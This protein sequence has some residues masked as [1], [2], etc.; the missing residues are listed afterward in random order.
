MDREDTVD[1]APSRPELSRLDFLR[2]F[3]PLSTSLLIDAMERMSSAGD[4]YP[5]RLSEFRASLAISDVS[6]KSSLDPESFRP[7]LVFLDPVF[8]VLSH[9]ASEFSNGT[10][11]EV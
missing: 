10:W 5:S 11:F 2:D 3:L 9:W 4:P 1:A 7:F 6:K 8:F